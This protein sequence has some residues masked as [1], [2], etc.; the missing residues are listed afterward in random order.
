MRGLSGGLS[1][2]LALIGMLTS[3]GG[4]VANEFKPILIGFIMLAGAAVFA[5]LHIGARAKSARAGQAVNLPL[6]QEFEN[7]AR[8]R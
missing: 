8:E 6:A 2:A 1:A 3:I 5:L 4:V 7:Y